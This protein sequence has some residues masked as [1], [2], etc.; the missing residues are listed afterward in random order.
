MKYFAYG[1]NLDLMQMAQRCPGAKVIGVAQLADHR[2]CFPRRSPVRGCAVASIEPHPGEIIWGVIYEL[3]TDDL[4]RLDAREGYDPINLGAVNRY[5]RKDIVVQRKPG[6]NVDAVAYVALREDNPGR[7]S[8]DYMKHIIDGAVE[9]AFPDAYIDMLKS[10][11]V[12]DDG[13]SRLDMPSAGNDE[14][15]D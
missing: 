6:E 11:E 2:I 10:I 12:S 7:P 5:E 9:H 3:D 4:K 15:K 1:S 14:A 8:V 13:F